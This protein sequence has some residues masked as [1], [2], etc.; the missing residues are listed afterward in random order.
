[1]LWSALS[2]STF[3][4]NLVTVASIVSEKHA[5]V[6][7]SDLW[8]WPLWPWPLVK[9]IVLY[10]MGSAFSQITFVPNL[11]T[12]AWIVSEKHANVY[13]SDLWPWPLWPWPLTLTFVTL[14]LTFGQGHSVRNYLK[15]IIAK[16]LCAKFGDCSF[17][18]FRDTCRCFFLWPLTLTFV[19][20]LRSGSKVTKR[21]IGMYLGNYWSYSHQIW[22][23]GSWR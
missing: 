22:H 8:P 15:R 18:S 3:V 9:V 17:N 11:V 14:T 23:K 16:N 7:F 2:P 6:Y 4:P 19:I 13:F 21:N 1:M 10:M 5:N 20:D 12:V